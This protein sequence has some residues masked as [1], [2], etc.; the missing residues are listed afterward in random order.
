[1]RIKKEYFSTKIEEAELDQKQLFQLSK[2]IMGDKHEIILPTHHDEKDLA[3]QFC[4]F[5][6]NKIETIRRNLCASNNSSN[7]MFDILSADKRFTGEHL[8]SFTSTSISEVSKIIQSA[9]SKHCELDPIPTHLLKSCLNELLPAM[10]N[11]VNRSLSESHVPSTINKE[12][13]V[14]P[15]LKKPSLD[16]EVLKNYRPVSNRTFLLKV[17]EKVVA[18][19]LE[20]HI[21]SN[22]LHDTLQSAVCI[23]SPTFHR[24]RSSACISRY[25]FY[26]GQKL[27]CRSSD[28]RSFGCIRRYRSHHIVRTS[29]LL[30]RYLR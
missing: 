21:D 23:P 19:Q 14:R 17:L 3:N 15:L 2:S 29:Q 22:S 28:A 26:I 7:T 4:E 16:R 8:S 1:M 11:I 18:A 5:F 20:H 6:L 9:P 30:I 27:L 25:C 24:N 13:I 10:T 12:A